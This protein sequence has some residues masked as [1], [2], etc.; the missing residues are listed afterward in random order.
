MMDDH[1]H[2]DR[3]DEMILDFCDDDRIV[4]AMKFYLKLKDHCRDEDMLIECSGRST[5]APRS[6]SSRNI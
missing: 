2:R 4:E 6:I 5:A 3:S 1:W